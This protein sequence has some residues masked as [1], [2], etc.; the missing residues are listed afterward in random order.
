MLH[1]ILLCLSFYFFILG[2]VIFFVSSG[3]NLLSWRE[4]C[5]TPADGLFAFLHKLPHVALK[6]DSPL[7]LTFYICL[8]SL[9]FTGNYT[10]SRNMQNIIFCPPFGLTTEYRQIIQIKRLHFESRN[11]ILRCVYIFILLAF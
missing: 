4:R 9:S 10:N 1:E 11:K 3:L 6:V 2:R 8:F 5:S 7:P